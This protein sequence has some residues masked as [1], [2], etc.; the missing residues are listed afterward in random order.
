[1]TSAIGAFGFSSRL[2]PAFSRLCGRLSRLDG[3]G[4]LDFGRLDLGLSCDLFDI[5]S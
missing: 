2:K 5:P 1:M 3:L 4:L